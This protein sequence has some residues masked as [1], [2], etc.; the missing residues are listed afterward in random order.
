MNSH[1]AEII[2]LKRR[3]SKLEDL[4]KTLMQ[5]DV[6][7]RNVS[8]LDEDEEFISLHPV[9][10][11]FDMFRIK[12]ELLQKMTQPSERY[13]KITFDNY[14]DVARHK[15]YQNHLMVDVGM[16]DAQRK[17]LAKT[18]YMIADEMSI[19]DEFECPGCGEKV[20]KKTY[21]HRFCGVKKRGQSNCKDFINNWFNPKRLERTLKWLES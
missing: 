1:R 3:V 12:R 6:T 2:A 14:P 4:V 19:G 13:L 17:K 18:R 10:D 20:I 16:S 21:Q 9:D 8:E 11:M 5:R 15:V 7:P